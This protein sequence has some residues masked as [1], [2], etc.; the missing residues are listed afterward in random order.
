MASIKKNFFY[1]SIFTV[2]GYLFPLLTYPYVSRVLGVQNIG[3][4]NFVDSIINYFV[5][6]SMMGTVAVG[7][8]EIAANK[9]GSTL[10]QTFSSIIAINV[11][12]TVLAIVGLLVS[13]NIVESLRPYRSLLCIGIV[14]LVGNFMMIE[15]LY[16]GLEDFEYITKRSIF[17]KCLYVLG[18]FLFVNNPS[19]LMKYFG[20]SCAM[21]GIN[22]LFNIIHARKIVHF[23]FRQIRP[24]KYIKAVLSL[25]FYIIIGS[26]YTSFNVV[27]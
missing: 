15:W 16:K 1:S 8:R 3:V 2:S 9:K 11:C 26:M 27:F 14:K 10:N 24:V 21:Y 4:C 18:V 25:G 17:V 19:D 12:L 7:I 5:Y 22:A 6:L 20:L 13:M 23:C